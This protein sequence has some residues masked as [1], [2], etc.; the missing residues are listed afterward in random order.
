MHNTSMHDTHNSDMT[1]KFT[2][3]LKD[4]AQELYAEPNS[5]SDKLHKEIEGCIGMKII[6][7]KLL[8]HKTTFQYLRNQ[9][10]KK[11]L[12]VTR[13]LTAMFDENFEILRI[14]HDDARHLVPT[15]RMPFVL[16]IWFDDM[17]IEKNE[18]IPDVKNTMPKYY[19]TYDHFYI[20]SDDEVENDLSSVTTNSGLF[21]F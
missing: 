2:E 8:R 14:W 17:N 13:R 5:L 11:Q 15:T 20:H 21:V 1:C 10:R 7:T 6:H 18:C 3:L 9:R 19:K 12:R 16:T 4:A